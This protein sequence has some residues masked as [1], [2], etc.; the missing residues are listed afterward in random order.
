V[1]FVD[2]QAGSVVANTWVRGICQYGVVPANGLLYV[3]PHS[4]ACSSSDLIKSGFM[5]L[6]PASKT[7]EV[8][9]GKRRRVE[10]GES[11]RVEEGKGRKVEEWD[12]ASTAALEHDRLQRGSAYDSNLS[13]PSNRDSASS[14]W[15]T[16][17]HDPAR[18]GVATCE[19]SLD[20]QIAWETE[21]FGRLT[22]PVV[23]GGVLLVA[24][25]DRHYVH[26]L[27]AASGRGL[28]SFAAGARID[29][30]PTIDGGRVLFG[31]A[32]GYV[33]CLRLAD[34]ELI[35]RFRAAP[36]ERLIVANGQL[37]S[38]WPV[39]GSVLV[40]DGTAYFVAGRSSYLDGGMYFYKL[41]A[42]TGRP[43]KI[44]ALEV[45]P[46]N[47]DAGVATGGNL[48]DVLSTDGDSL[49][50]RNARFDRELVR[51]K[52]NVPHLWSSVGFLDDSWWH[53]TYWQYGTSM[54]SGWGGWAKAGQ[55]VPAGRLLVTDGTR[56]F[57]YGRNQYDTPGAHVGIDADGVWGP[58][59][60][61][62][63]RWT[64]YQLFGRAIDARSEEQLR[65]GAK[66]APASESDWK[67]RIPVLAQ[68]MVLSGETLFVA[69]PRDTVDEIPH[70][71]S[72][73]DPLAEALQSDQ[74]GHLLA[75]S[76]TDGA[77][78]TEREL[79]SPPIFDGMAAAGGRLYLSTKNGQI[80]CLGPADQ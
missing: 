62:L 57:G 47:R 26:G 5:A 13:S 2:L 58:I 80:V 15:P 19:V 68:G 52:E 37:E 29:S 7:E 17:R 74:G 73:V 36:H 66:P 27:D 3:P 39:P 78:L 46:E 60:G 8:E 45:A 11:R 49:F 16:Y 12:G 61:Q 22:S 50:L 33:Y 76:T 64:F 24:E 18:S 35:W 53:R 70:E 72:G 71:P 4:C 23:A 1:E 48:P 9:E 34:G 42:V 56:V 44:E 63:G 41:N 79:T 67:R 10:E 65:R 25:A 32:D 55:R 40:L 51:Q 69:G 77:T 6:A 21:A 38:A 43:L 31:S 20:L 30:P 75:I 28:W 14:D 54:S 59:A